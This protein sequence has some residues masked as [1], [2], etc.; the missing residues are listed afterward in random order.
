MKYPN[1]NISHI[2]E[3]ASMAIISRVLPKEWIIRELTERDYGIDLYVE[4]V[5]ATGEVT[6]DMVGLQ[7][8]SKGGF[9]FNSKGLYSIGNIKISTV[10]Y[11]LGLPV[12][13]FLLLVDIVDEKVY[14]ASVEALNRNGQFDG[15]SKTVSMPFRK[16]F[17]F[18]TKGLDLFKVAYFREK[19]WPHVERAIEAALMSYNTLGPLF[20]MCKR[21]R[22][23]F[24]TSTIQYMLLQHYENFSMLSRYLIFKTPRRLPYWYKRHIEYIKE[25]GGRASMTFSY[26]IIREMLKY[27]IWRYRDCI[28]AAY[29]LI[30]QSDGQ[31]FRRR[32]PY[33][34]MHLEARP[35]TFID[36]DW[37][38]RYYFDEYEN[39]TQN[40]EKLFFNDFSEFDWLLEDD[41]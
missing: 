32:F 34:I 33:L 28:I 23:E 17:S 26:E 2:S 25:N 29:E 27:F 36:E 4:I 38:A 5:G 11:W 37:G 1:R 41:R 12:P 7:V 35:H 6:G 10:N 22:D 13:V 19:S 16:E 18:N 9:E 3:S 20:L 15:T 31:Y 30:T 21:A 39:E 14:W 40:P 24:C 8:K